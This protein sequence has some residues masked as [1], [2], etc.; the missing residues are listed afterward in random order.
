MIAIIKDTQQHF[1]VNC[2]LQW[3]SLFI[4]LFALLFQFTLDKSETQK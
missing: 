2:I 1:L 3:V 4:Y